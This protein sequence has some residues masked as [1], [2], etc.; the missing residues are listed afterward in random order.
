MTRALHSVRTLPWRAFLRCIALLLERSFRAEWI[1]E[2]QAELWHAERS[3]GSKGLSL[4]EVQAELARF[5]RG[6]LCDAALIRW[7]VFRSHAFRLNADSERHATALASPAACLGWLL[8]GCLAFASVAVLVPG[9]R[10]AL[11]PARNRGAQATVRISR[12][13]LAGSGSPTIRLD[14]YRQWQAQARNL[15]AAIAFYRAE[16]KRVHFAAHRSADLSLLIGTGSLSEVIPLALERGS[17]AAQATDTRAALVLSDAAWRRYFRRDPQI[18]GS[19]ARI[20]EQRVRIA[21]IASLQPSSGQPGQTM[22]PPDAWLLETDAQIE[23]WPRSTHGFVVATVRPAV[24]ASLPAERWH[25][26]VP[27]PTGD[28]EFECVTVADHFLRTIVVF[29]FTAI[30]ALLALPATTSLRLGEYGSAYAGHHSGKRMRRWLFLGAKFSLALALIFFITLDL[31]CLLTRM[32]GGAAGLFSFPACLAAFRWIL[33]DQRQRCP[34]CLRLLRNPARVGQPS[35]VF[36]AWNGT[37]MMCAD[38]HGLLH[39]PEL[40]TSW[41]STQRWLSLD[42][43][44][45]G[46]FHPTGLAPSVNP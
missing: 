37:E 27:Q 14:Q 13:G 21:A 11:L 33:R 31:D 46:L 18:V 22:P 32:H 34:V 28:E 42:S 25:M 41:F 6:A 20:G 43:S 3:L 8:L 30:L 39:V 26:T 24:A 38:G 9:A 44:W 4:F 12:D 16:Q 40:P 7:Q 45:N 23:Q 5:T 1:R 15:F 35:R 2:W 19:E 10:Q 36:L 29:L 17:L